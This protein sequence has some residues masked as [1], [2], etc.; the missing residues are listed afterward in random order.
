[1]N[2]SLYY[3]VFISSGLIPVFPSLIARVFS[4]PYCDASSTCARAEVREVEEAIPLME[5]GYEKADEIN[6][7]HLYRKQLL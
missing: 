4:Y 1:M 7:V 5:E 3:S 6:G 2:P